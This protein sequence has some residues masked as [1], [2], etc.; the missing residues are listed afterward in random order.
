MNGFDVVDRDGDFDDRDN[1]TQKDGKKTCL[2]QMVLY[3]HK[4]GWLGS[5]KFLMHAFLMICY[6]NDPYHIAFYLSSANIQS[7]DPNFKNERKIRS[8]TSEYI[9][10]VLLTLDILITC[11]TSYQVD[12]RWEK[13][14]FKILWNYLKGTLIFDIVS[15]V[16]ALFLD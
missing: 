7:S 13:D 1:D 3:P 6:F 12:V 15:T 14:V 11:V 10:D 16:P 8:M 9:I 4:S 5:W 2:E